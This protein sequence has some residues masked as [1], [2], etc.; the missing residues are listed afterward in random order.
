MKPVF[1]T[2]FVSVSQ[3][4]YLNLSNLC[5]FSSQIH[6]KYTENQNKKKTI[7]K[8][9]HRKKTYLMNCI[10]K[11]KHSGNKLE[12]INELVCDKQVSKID[13]I[14]FIFRWNTLL[15]RYGHNAVTIFQLQII[16]VSFKMNFRYKFSIS[17]FPLISLSLSL[18]P[19]PSPPLS[20]TVC[21]FCCVCLCI[22]S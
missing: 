9:K 15:R 21:L 17:D 5:I 6:P 3:K 10:C 16:D 12:N 14:L 18:C 22:F 4:Y 19:A 7:F 1:S 2:T 20:V 11:H 8:K 13:Y